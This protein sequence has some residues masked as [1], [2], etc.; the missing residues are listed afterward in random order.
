IGPDLK[1][2]IKKKINETSNVTYKG[3]VENPL[4][5]LYGTSCLI[6]PIFS[7]AGVKVKV[8]DALSSGTPIIGTHIAFEGID[9]T[10]FSNAM[11]LCNNENDF[12]DKINNFEF[13]SKEQSI[14]LINKVK[15]HYIEHDFISIIDS[16]ENF[17]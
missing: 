7:G 5:E 1:N 16:N 2:S 6:A 3:F 14:E 9:D 15:S 11:F 10:I 13:W 8:L 17:N 4:L 12:V